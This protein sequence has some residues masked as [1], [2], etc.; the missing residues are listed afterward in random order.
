M[1]CQMIILEV[2]NSG[3]Q[4]HKDFNPVKPRKKQPTIT[5]KIKELPK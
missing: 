4:K 3:I 1:D 5:R 2:S